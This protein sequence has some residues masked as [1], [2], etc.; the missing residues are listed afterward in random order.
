MHTETCPLSLHDA[1]PILAQAREKKAAL[2]GAMRK[3][4]RL[5][6]L[7]SERDRLAKENGELDEKI[8]AKRDRLK[9]VL[10]NSWRGMLSG[11]RSEE[12]T[13]ELQSPMYLVCRLL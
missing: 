5:G 1:L 6:A 11:K 2:E 7:L 12:H 4:E 13:S 10:A 8:A 3:S 9:E